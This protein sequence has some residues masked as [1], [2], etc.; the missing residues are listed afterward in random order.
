[1]TP[2]RTAKLRALPAVG[3][4]LETDI[5]APWIA[6]NS[7]SSVVEAL[8]SAVDRVRAAVVQGDDDSCCDEASILRVAKEILSRSSAMHLKPVINATGIVL[9][10]GLGRAPLSQDAVRAI[11]EGAGGYVNLEYDLEAGARGRR[12]GH[13]AERLAKLTGAEAATI[14]NNNAAAVLLALRVLC[15]GREVIISRGQLV[16]IGGS[17]RMPD[18][19]AASGAIMREVGT[20]NRTRVDDYAAAVTEQTGALLRVHH[21]NFRIVGFTREASIGDIVRC[22]H[23]HNLLAIDDVGSGAMFDL[24]SVGMPGEPHIHESVEAGSDIIC[25]SGDKLLGGPQAGIILG[26]RELIQRID[27]HPLMRTY[28]VDKLVLLALEATLRHF[29]DPADAL[30]HIPT[31]NMM[32]ATTDTLA[33]NARTLE[34]LL[35]ESLADEQFFISS[36][37]S[38]VGGGA[39]PGEEIATVVIRWQ[40]SFGSVDEVATALRLASPPVI[41]RIK[42]QSIC[43]DL[44]TVQTA[45]FAS[46]V[47][48]VASVAT[49]GP[50]NA[51]TDP[52]NGA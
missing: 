27:A 39:L 44:R 23:D 8:R 7:R 22:A 49:G 28:R 32:H 1:M 9:H 12:T 26:R 5:V 47:R 40:P 45:E 34:K 30:K 37:V 35:A 46:F 19:M 38:Y 17:F 43:F 2:E 10:T 36:D 50:E 14:V 51:E 42:D 18:V 13:V 6:S 48:S 41:A 16:E 24:T 3:E 4:L 33:Q 11:A 21:S 15:E 31:L 20:T 52:A 29:D 25:F